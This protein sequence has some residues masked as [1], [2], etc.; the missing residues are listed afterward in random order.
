MTKRLGG[1]V[2][3]DLEG[4]HFESGGAETEGVKELESEWGSA[5]GV[6]GLNVSLYSRWYE[7][8]GSTLGCFSVNAMVDDLIGGYTINLSMKSEGCSIKHAVK[9]CEVFTYITK[10]EGA[11]EFFGGTYQLL[12]C[13]YF[14]LWGIIILRCYR[15][16]WRFRFS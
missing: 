16:I 13:I 10:F 8:S 2:A 11:E 1:V 7:C 14:G 9:C 15:M 6:S 12:Y 3:V 4:G 5:E